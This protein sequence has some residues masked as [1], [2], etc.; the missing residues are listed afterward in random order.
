MH[1]EKKTRLYIRLFGLLLWWGKKGSRKI[2]F[3][4]L[5]AALFYKKQKK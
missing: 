4:L 5:K 2:K 1:H 3:F